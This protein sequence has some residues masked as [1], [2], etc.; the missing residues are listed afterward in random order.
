M[1]RLPAKRAVASRSSWSFDR[2]CHVPDTIMVDLTPNGQP[3]RCMNLRGCANRE[4]IC[5]VIVRKAPVISGYERSGT[6]TDQAYWRKL[7]TM[8]YGYGW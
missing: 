8:P 2:R 7:L 3:R 5:D 4:F 6:G 1:W